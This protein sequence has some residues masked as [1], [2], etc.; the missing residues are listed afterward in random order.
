VGGDAAA[1]A[2]ALLYRIGLRAAFER[3]GGLVLVEREN[4]QDILREMNLGVSDLAAPD[5][6]TAVGRLL[7]QPAAGGD[8]EPQR[9]AAAVSAPG[10]HGK[11]ARAGSYPPSGSDGDVLAVSERWRRRSKR[12]LWKSGRRRPRLSSGRLGQRAAWAP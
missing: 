10:G 8:W 12:A 1:E 2:Q 7:R 9:T 6:R 5:A 4:L 11:H 3:L